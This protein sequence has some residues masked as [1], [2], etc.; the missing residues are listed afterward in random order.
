MMVGEFVVSSKPFS[1]TSLDATHSTLSG[2][3]EDDCVDRC[4]PNDVI[5]PLDEPINADV[6]V[7]VLVNAN[8][9]VTRNDTGIPDSGT[10]VPLVSDDTDGDDGDIFCNSYSLTTIVSISVH[11]RSFC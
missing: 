2:V 8:V 3:V 11:C 10:I 6:V 4:S 1:F 7:L 9:V 5:F